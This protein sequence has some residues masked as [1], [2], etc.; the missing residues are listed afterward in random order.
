MLTKNIS[1]CGQ[2]DREQY[3]QLFKT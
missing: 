1:L 3:V 2:N